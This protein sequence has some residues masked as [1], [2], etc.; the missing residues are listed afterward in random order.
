MCTQ[1][2]KFT[3]KKNRRIFWE[4]NCELFFLWMLGNNWTRHVHL[5]YLLFAAIISTRNS[6]YSNV[7]LW[8]KKKKWS[9]K[10]QIKY[11]TNHKIMEADKVKSLG[12]M[13]YLPEILCH[14]IK[15][16]FSLTNHRIWMLFISRSHQKLLWLFF[17][18]RQTRN[19]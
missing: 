12:F 2:A 14:L 16:I 8:R 6:T 5:I 18:Y 7:T 17:I 19:H 9:E 1:T 11:A 10:Y 3:P 13:R 15:M 4:T